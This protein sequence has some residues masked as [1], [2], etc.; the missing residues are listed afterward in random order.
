MKRIP[1]IRFTTLCIFA[2]LIGCGGGGGGGSSGPDSDA[3]GLIGLSTRIVNGSTCSESDSPVV[4]LVINFSDGTS[5]TCSGAL[6]SSRTIVSAA[7]C[8]VDLE[9]A[10]G[11]RAVSA[12]ASVEGVDQSVISFAVHPDA[13]VAADNASAINDVAVATLAQAVA[14]STLP[15][16]VSSA[17]GRGD[18]ISIYGYGIDQD[19]N[20]GGLRSGEMQIDSIDSDHI[21]ALFNGQ[22]SNTC[23]GDSGGPAIVQAR[24]S[25]GNTFAALVG[26]TSTGALANCGSGDTSLFT[27]LQGTVLPF[28]EAS[29]S[30]ARFE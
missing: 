29:A 28:L 4:R 23:G 12:I 6:V 11:P 2:S 16:L 21:F 9:D 27:N 30:G 15:I 18:I 22:G 20:F 19:G 8:F 10:S 26:V 1:T 24:D 3:C 7:H 5:G 25:D 17:P 13:S 14:T